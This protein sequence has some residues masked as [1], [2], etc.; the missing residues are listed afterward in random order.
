MSHMI[1]CDRCKE[2]FYTDSRSEKDAYCI[3][4]I[5]Y[6]NGHSTIH[7][8]KICHREFIVNFLKLMSYEEYLDNY[9]E[10]R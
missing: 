6:I 10:V 2:H 5:D 1:E 7:L 3:I 9:G 4:S 8:C